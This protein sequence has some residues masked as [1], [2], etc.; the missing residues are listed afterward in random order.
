MPEQMNSNQ[1]GSFNQSNSSKKGL[2][3]LIIG[4][5]VLIA[6]AAFLVVQILSSTTTK[7]KEWNAV[8]LTNGRTYFGHVTKETSSKVVLEDVYYFQVRQVQDQEGQ[9]Q[10]QV[11]LQSLQSEM[12]GPTNRMEI[13]RDHV[14][15]VEK[16]SQN[17]QVLAALNQQGAG[18]GFQQA[19]QQ[20]VPSQQAPQQ[21][22][23]N[24]Q[25]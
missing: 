16:L 8:S 1:G 17:S 25:Q 15:F 9:T 10:P 19:P 3:F 14:L 23:T 12:H 5:I 6:V 11:S 18:A 20:Q 4:I 21:Q 22:Q 24:P 7:A 13:N 2:I